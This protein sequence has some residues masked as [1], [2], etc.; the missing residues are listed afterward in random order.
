MMNLPPPLNGQK[1]QNPIQSPM[2]EMMGPEQMQE[3]QEESMPILAHFDPEEL[4]ELDEAQ[5]EIFI[6]PE[7]NLRDYRPLSKIMKDPAI[8]DLITQALSG[9]N[10]NPQ[11]AMGGTVEEPG[12]PLDP[13]LEKLRLEGRHG[14]S[15]LAIIT[16]ELLEMFTQWSGKEPDIN[17]ETGLPEFFSFK[18]IIKSIV[19]VVG[20]ALGPV[21]GFAASK[22]TG[23]STGAA[24]KNAFFGAALPFAAMALPSILGAVGGTGGAGGFLSSLGKFI[25]GFGGAGT[26]GGLISNLAGVGRMLPG[27]GAQAASQGIG[28]GAAQQMPQA[29]GQT[30]GGILGNLLQGV[31]PL[32]G[33]ALMMAKG[34]NEEKKNQSDYENKQRQEGESMRER[35]GFNT[36]L[37]KARPFEFNPTNPRISKEDYERGVSPEYFNYDLKDRHAGGGPIKGEGKGQQDNIHKNLKDGSYIIDASTVSDIGDGSSQAGSQELDKY[38][39]KIPSMRGENYANGGFIKAMVSNDEYEISPEKVTALG[40]GSNEKGAKILDKFVK[41][42]RQKKRTSGEKLP[43]KAKPVDG[44]LKRLNAA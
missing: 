13:E 2:P 7:T 10:D 27:M 41:E 14:D 40:K 34:A 17:P 37:R 36:P 33:S 32:A 15:E 28:Q 19:R 8:Q 21:T 18:N 12:R 9:N 6:D 42:I 11:F 4:S 30:G 16:P 29:A 25:P 5:G 20:T 24:L 44:Y 22:L 38:F 23:Q 35:L 31:L 39:S 26:G 1:M 43:P 3:I